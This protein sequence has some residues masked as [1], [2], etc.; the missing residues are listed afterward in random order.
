MSLLYLEDLTPGRTF[1]TDAIEV[2]ETMIHAFAR[3]FDPQPFHLDAAAADASLFR[4][5]AAS[6]WHTLALTMG[7]VV[8]SPM[9]IANGH[10]GMGVEGVRWPRPVRAG[11][12]LR[13]TIEV[14][15]VTPSRSQP[16]WGVMRARWTTRNQH[17][18]TVAVATPSY[19]VQARGSA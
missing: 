7:L 17:G 16:G 1:E 4:G 5:L 12:T 11:D 13:V 14:L 15:D 9:T 19:W 2:T 6:G 3:D 8:R 10:V 18:E